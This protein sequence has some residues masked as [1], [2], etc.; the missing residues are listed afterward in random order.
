MCGIAGWFSKDIIAESERHSLEKML[1]FI[2]H[3]GPDGSGSIIDGNAALTHAR[4]SIIDLDK[5]SQ[6]MLSA[7]GQRWITYNGEI[8]NYRSLREGLLSRGCNF[9]SNSD[10]EAILNLYQ[11][12]GIKGFSKLRGMYAFAIWDKRSGKA[13]LARDT[14]GIKPLFYH[15]SRTGELSFA[16]EAKAIVSREKECADLNINALHLLMNFRYLPSQETLFNNILQ[17]KPGSVLEWK[18]N[19]EVRDYNIGAYSE[20]QI[21]DPMEA[22]ENSIKSHL[23]ADV[24]VG[25][26]LSGGVDSAAI[27]KIASDNSN[28]K[29]RTY[30]LNVGDDPDEARN[31]AE[32]A[33]LFGLENKQSN[34]DVNIEEVLPKLIWHL[35]VPK[36]NALQVSENARHASGET[37]VVLSGMGGDE[38]FYGYNLHSWMH[39]AQM[40]SHCVP[41]F[42]GETISSIGLGAIKHSDLPVWSEQER[43]LRLLPNLKHAPN[44]YG[45]FRNIWDSPQ[46]RRVI[47]GPRVLDAELNDAYGLLSD[48]WPVNQDSVTSAAMFEWQH[49]MVNDLLWQEDRCSMAF[50]LEVRVPFLDPVLKNSLANLHRKELMPFGRK[51]GLLKK[52][53]RETLPNE[54]LNRKKSGF[55]VDAATFFNENL[56]SMKNYLLSEEITLSIGLFNPK[57]IKS[58][59]KLK[60]SKIHRWHYFMLYMIMMVHLW[61]DIFEKQKGESFNL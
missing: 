40:A 32:T 39:Y 25:S 2:R 11:A 19:G 8:Y 41:Q 49:K 34:L 18:T 51:K 14:I 50:G 42:L 16:S 20:I 17:L 4:L 47:Y 27:T 56:S 13:I 60:S 38:L 30:T 3:R 9:V 7:D 54:I 36:I 21:D 22:L 23:V 43:A 6:P 26:F 48:R 45:L 46:L 29:V 12:E 44:L 35:E 33:G 28:S 15:I 31:A 58:L 55:Q 59:V 52:I 57:F 10:T 53:L 24:E 37:K 61:V 1:H 5:G